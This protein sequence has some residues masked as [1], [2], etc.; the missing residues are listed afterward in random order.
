[1]DTFKDL[2]PN[3]CCFIQTWTQ[4]ENVSANA[5]FLEAPLNPGNEV[6][7]YFARLQDE[8]LHIR[9]IPRMPSRKCQV[10]IRVTAGGGTSVSPTATI[11]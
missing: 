2:A 6:P 1:M 4:E 7:V 11:R 10:V 9:H 3:Y 8:D 5:R